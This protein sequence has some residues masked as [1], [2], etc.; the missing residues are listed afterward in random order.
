MTFIVE[1]EPI[2]G[3]IE[4]LVSKSEY[5]EAMFRNNMRESIEKKVVVPNV[6]R[7][8]FLKLLEYLCLEDSRSLMI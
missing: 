2:Y 6:S 4:I 8:A 3:N 7:T 1:N 5:F